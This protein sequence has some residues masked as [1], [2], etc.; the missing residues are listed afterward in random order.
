MI[1]MINVKTRKVNHNVGLEKIW[2]FLMVVVDN[3]SRDR[4]VS[5]WS[6]TLVPQFMVRVMF[7]LVFVI[8]CNPFVC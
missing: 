7:C 3:E 6:L 1:M 4:D 8:D 5:F 2:S